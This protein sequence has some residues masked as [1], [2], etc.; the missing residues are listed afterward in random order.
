MTSVQFTDLHFRMSTLTVF[1]ALLADPVID[2][3]GL[4][5]TRA[6]VVKDLLGDG[7]DEEG[8]DFLSESYEIG[9]AH[10]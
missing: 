10:V 3:L 8:R 6:S 1:R 7:S 5:V 4:C 2:A 9:R